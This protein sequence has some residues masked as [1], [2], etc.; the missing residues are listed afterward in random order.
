LDDDLDARRKQL[1]DAGEEEMAEARAAAADLAVR[2]AAALIVAQGSSAIYAGEHAQR[3]Y[4]EAAFLLVFGSRA[5]I[6]A[7]LLRRLGATP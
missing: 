2:A 7:S 1:D 5:S 3:L 6:K 4:R